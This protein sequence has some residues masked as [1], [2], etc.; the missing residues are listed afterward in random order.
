MEVKPAVKWEK[1]VYVTG[2]DNQEF[3]AYY[4]S[5]LIGPKALSNWSS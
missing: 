5:R 1:G 3:H 2:T 4:G